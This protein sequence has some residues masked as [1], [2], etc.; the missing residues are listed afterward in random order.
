MVRGRWSSSCVAQLAATCWSRPYIVSHNESFK[1]VASQCSHQ[2]DQLG[3]TPSSCINTQQIK[4]LPQAGRQAGGRPNNMKHQKGIYGR[5]HGE[6][7]R[8]KD[9]HPPGN[10][11]FRNTDFQPVTTFQHQN[12]KSNLSLSLSL[13]IFCKSDLVQFKLEYLTQYVWMSILGEK[14]T[15]NFI[16]M[17]VL[18]LKT[19]SLIIDITV[20][21]I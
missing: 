2:A 21:D 3:Y 17:I 8:V 1:Q 5:V 13:I 15:G 12:V 11:V 10:T 20:P 9:K 16:S 18:P 7:V 19:L 6:V 14:S 4:S